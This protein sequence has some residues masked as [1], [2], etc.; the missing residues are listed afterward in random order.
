MLVNT[1]TG[2][3]LLL[4]LPDGFIFLF[5]IDRYLSSSAFLCFRAYLSLQIILPLLKSYGESSRVTLS[6]G[7]IRI[8][9]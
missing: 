8:K 5:T 6:P 2:N 9:F 7:K 3:P 4:G 1:E